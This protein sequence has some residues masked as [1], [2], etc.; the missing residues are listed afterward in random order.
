MTQSSVR[1]IKR[2]S[3]KSI[4]LRFFLIT[5]Y[6]VA[7]DFRWL[8]FPNEAESKIVSLSNFIH[9]D[10]DIDQKLREERNEI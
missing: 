3:E 8:C 4:E 1:N 6:E 2:S 9:N 7:S 10:D 5:G